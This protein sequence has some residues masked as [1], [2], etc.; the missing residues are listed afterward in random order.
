[1]IWVKLRT[2]EKTTADFNAGFIPVLVGIKYEIIKGVQ[3]PR[4]GPK[5]YEKPITNKYITLPILLLFSLFLQ[6]AKLI[7]H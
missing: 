4:Q 3:K 2:A 6:Q 5:K 7:Y 1:M